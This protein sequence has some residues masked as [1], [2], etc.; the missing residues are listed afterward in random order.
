M[1]VGG[2]IVLKGV[3]K[4]MILEGLPGSGGVWER[5]EA[6]VGWRRG[7]RGVWI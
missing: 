4:E 1:R 2:E 7:R 3:G 5:V 6:G